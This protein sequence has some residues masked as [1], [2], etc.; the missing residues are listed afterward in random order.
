LAPTEETTSSASSSSTSSVPAVTFRDV[1][2]AAWYAAAVETLRARGIVEGLKTKDG[3]PTG[4]F[5]PARS[6]THAELLKMA[7][8]AA[9]KNPASAK[10]AP[11][12]PTARG[13]W[14]APYVAMA[15]DLKLSLFAY[16]QISPVHA[17]ATRA[18]AIQT[19]VDLFAPDAPG[20]GTFTFTDLPS[21]HPN[22][23]AIAVAFK[24]GWVRGDT[25]ERGFPTGTF[26]PSD[27]I[28]RAEVAKILASIL[29]GR[30]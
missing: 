21:G 26:R 18:Q 16:G 13:T 25:D 3:S 15:E 28:S 7:L 22:R 14:A 30:L 2:K 17:P 12:N 6:V 9:G 24:L 23:Q 10:T 20:S 8:L 4:L 5:E 27:T 29:K 19:L 1:P 11:A